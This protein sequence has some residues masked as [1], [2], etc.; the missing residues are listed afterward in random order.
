MQIIRATAEHVDLIAP[1]FDL[2]RQFYKY[3]PDLEGARRFIHERL[4]NGESV[5]FLA[6]DDSGKAV[7]FT[8]LYPT[9][10]S[11]TLRSMWIL[12]DL[13]VRSDC[14]KGG[15][16]SALMERARQLGM[17]TGAVELMLETAVDNFTAQRLY[18]KLGWKRDQEFYTYHLYLK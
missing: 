5:I 13:Y 10:S 16:A 8:Q 12:N 4:T 17:E 6:L 11:T 18:E 3:E 1:L 15:V 14:R 7:G 9:F 2:Y